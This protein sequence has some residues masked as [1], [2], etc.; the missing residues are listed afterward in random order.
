VPSLSHADDRTA[1][2]SSATNRVA[3]EAIGRLGFGLLRDGRPETL[4]TWRISARDPEVVARVA[5]LFRGVP[6]KST[7]A[8]EYTWH[9]VT[10]TATVDVIL[11]GPHAL[12]VCWR[13]DGLGRRCDGLEQGKGAHCSCGSLGSLTERK[14]AA[15]RGHGCV[16]NIEMSFQLVHDPTVGTFTFLSGN[17]SFAEQ[18]IMTKAALA[19]LAV[20]TLIQLGL[21]QTRHILHGGRSVTYTRPTLALLSTSLPN[22]GSTEASANL[23]VSP[24]VSRPFATGSCFT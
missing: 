24:Q 22:P 4:T 19:N 13:R 5:V 17:W 16:P 1:A 8:D 6:R 12:R 2:S 7:E 23:M 18:A 9:V 20:P 3:A 10:E 14:A 21:K 11:S 15:Q